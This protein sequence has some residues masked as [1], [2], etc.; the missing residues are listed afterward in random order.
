MT[1]VEF[2]VP[3]TYKGKLEYHHSVNIL[4]LYGLVGKIPRNPHHDTVLISPQ[5]LPKK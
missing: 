3:G 5:F 2:A 1:G 4:L